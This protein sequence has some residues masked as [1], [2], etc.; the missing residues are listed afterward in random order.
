MG[1]YAYV[2]SPQIIDVFATLSAAGIALVTEDPWARGVPL[3]VARLQSPGAVM[4]ASITTLDHVTF[5]L[6]TEKGASTADAAA[7]ILATSPVVTVWYCAVISATVVA[8]R[9][10]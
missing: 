2:A 10:T 7:K 8:T 3:A 1:L 9:A 4:L 6:V 5:A